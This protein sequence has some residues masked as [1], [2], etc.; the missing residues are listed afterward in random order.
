MTNFNLEIDGA[1]AAKLARVLGAT[2]SA[3][4]NA[5]EF[6]VDMASHKGD[7]FCVKG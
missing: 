4:H 7:E 5:D 6:Y 2:E 1:T 3:S